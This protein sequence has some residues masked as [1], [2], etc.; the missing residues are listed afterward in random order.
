MTQ[1]IVFEVDLEITE[2]RHDTVWEVKEYAVLRVLSVRPPESQ[3]IMP[4]E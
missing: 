3:E 1:G 4:L 2:E